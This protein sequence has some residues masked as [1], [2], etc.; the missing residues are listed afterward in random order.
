MV[1]ALDE[2]QA[3][4]GFNGGSV[5]HALR[6]AAQQQRQVGYVFAGSEPSL[7][8]KMIGPRRPFYKAGPVMRLQKIPADIFATFIESKFGRSG[9]RAEAGLGAAI[10][11]LA[12]DPMIIN[13]GRDPGNLPKTRKVPRPEQL[14]FPGISSEITVLSDSMLSSSERFMTTLPSSQEDFAFFQ[15]QRSA[16][17][18]PLPEASGAPLNAPET[19]DVSAPVDESSRETFSDPAAGWGETVDQ[20]EA[21]LPEFRRTEIENTTSVAIV[22]LNVAKPAKVPTVA[23]MAVLPTLAV[24]ASPPAEMVATAGTL[25][26]QVAVAVRSWVELSE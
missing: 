13:I 7:M 3:I 23:L 11:D 6:A 22:T 15:A 12:G 10:V 1:V 25:V 5:E 8:E 20:G 14:L 2:F 19:V 18:S 16:A 9:I 4:D 17:A 24:V 26:A 21:E